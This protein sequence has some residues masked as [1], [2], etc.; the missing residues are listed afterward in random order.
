MVKKGRQP[1]MEDNFQWKIT[2]NGRQPQKEYKPKR[3][4]GSLIFL[5]SCAHN[6]NLLWNTVNS[7]Q[8]VHVKSPVIAVNLPI[9]ELEKWS[10]HK[11]GI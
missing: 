10:L 1:Q 11:S 7:R 9:L 2:S 8:F 3:K 5:A 6:E 4:Q